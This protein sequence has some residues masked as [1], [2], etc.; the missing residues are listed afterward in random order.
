[1]RSIC[2]PKTLP[3]KAGAICKSP[4]L[5]LALLSGVSL[6]LVAN[7]SVPAR[8]QTIERRYAVDIAPSTMADGIRK[9]ERETGIAL[10]YSPDQIRGLHTQGV[11]GNMTIEQALGYLVRG[12]GLAVRRSGEGTY[13]IAAPWPIQSSSIEKP[14]VEIADVE[15]APASSQAA[16]PDPAPAQA[17]EQVVV[18]G[19]Q[20]LRNGYSSPTPLTVLS[21]ADLQAAAPTNMSDY[22]DKLPALAGSTGP[23]SSANSVS[24]GNGGVAALN[25]RHLGPNRTLVLL[26]GMRVGPSTENGATTAGEVDTSEFPDELISRVDIV[27]GGASAAYGSDALAGVVNFV[28]DKN[29]TGVKGT[30]QGGVTTYGDDWQYKGSLTAGINFLG[31]RGHILMSG[32]VTHTNGIL[33]GGVRS[34]VREGWDRIVN[35]DYT[36]TNGKPFYVVSPQ[37]GSGLYTPGGLIENTALRGT[38]FGA[39]GV[40]RNFNYG[41]VDSGSGYMIGGDW[42]ET[43]PALTDSGEQYTASLDDRL[44][45]QNFFTRVNYS[46]T[47]HIEVFGDFLY[48]NSQVL[49]YCCTSDELV[50]INS[51]NPFIPASVQARMTAE[52]ISSF[53]LGVLNTAAGAV[54]PSNQ[55]QK[56]FYALGADGDFDLLG[57]NWTWNVFGSRSVARITDRAVNSPVKA[58]FAQAVDVVTDP[59]TGYPICASTLTNPGDGCIPYNPMGTGVN[60]AAANAYALGGVSQMKTEIT[61]DD[62]GGVLRGQPFSL[63]AGTVSLATGIEHRNQSVNGVSSAT[64]LANGFFLGNYHPAIGSYSV[65]EGFIETVIPLAKD[66]SWARELDLNAAI[67]ETGYSTSGNVTTFKVGLTYDTP[68]DGFRIRATRSRDIRAPSLGELYS[69]GR[70]GQGGIIDPFHNNQSVPDILTPTVGNPKL[71][72]EVADQTGFGAVYQPDWFP[73]FSA[74]LD[75]FRIDMNSVI[76]SLSAQDEVDACYAGVQAYCPF[77]QRENG[78]IYIVTVAPANTAFEKERGFDLEASYQKDLADFGD[79]WSGTVAMRLLAT[80]TWEQTTVDPLGNVTKATGVNNGG[81]PHW[82]YYLSV[83]YD[84]SAYSVTWVGRGIG[85]GVQSRQYTQ[86]T[87][88]CPTLTAPYYTINDNRMPGAF[89]MDVNLTYHLKTQDLGA[90][91]LFLSVEN[92]ANNNPEGFFVGNNNPLYDRIGRIFRTGIRFNM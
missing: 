92:V 55:R 21:P 9:I 74:S 70:V 51:G 17:P 2:Q 3:A 33:H 48:S 84:A 31:G 11:I 18:T 80:N 39:G 36:A 76:S 26:D 91:D 49:S 40:P 44:A 86:C 6:V 45:R 65:T 13:V 14:L 56:G 53:Q 57:S 72:P 12:A 68:L 82:T 27:T 85:S 83:G 54:G 50:T 62:F 38:D 10:V 23:R 58:T 60:S 77:I 79:P 87:S 69:G 90:P 63:W 22:L 20:I 73:G 35:P 88:D 81:V 30:L 24:D 19:T 41:A 37:V 46:I 78:D 16:D 15:Q 66:Y 28:L 42:Q 34:W 61:Q 67:R 4:R 32:T 71:R 52:G 59:T 43:Y 64:D 5:K 25:L 29:F 89:Y 1:M 47:D 8:A 7:M 75:Y